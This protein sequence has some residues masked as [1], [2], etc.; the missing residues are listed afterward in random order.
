VRT[1][2]CGSS[3]RCT[4]CLHVALL[5]CSHS[6]G[7]DPSEPIT[8]FLEDPTADESKYTLAFDFQM[9]EAKKTGDFS[10]VLWGAHATPRAA[11]A[12]RVPHDVFLTLVWSVYTGEDQNHTPYDFSVT[13]YYNYSMPTAALRGSVVA[14]EPSAPSMSGVPLPFSCVCARVCLC[15]GTPKVKEHPTN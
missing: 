4:D 2:T 11:V 9:G 7:C 14:P 10:L 6:K 8:L 5:A 13:V 1:L 3:D 12:A 15:L